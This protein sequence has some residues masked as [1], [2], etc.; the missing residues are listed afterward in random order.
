MGPFTL[1]LEGKELLRF[2]H[3]YAVPPTAA[4]QHTSTLLN[5][6]SHV[7]NIRHADERGYQAEL[8][9]SPLTEIYLTGNYSESE[10]KHETAQSA[11]DMAAAQGADGEAYD[12][13]TTEKL[14]PIRH[15][16]ERVGRNAPCP[17]GSG[18][19]YKNCCMRKSN[20]A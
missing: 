19:K 16:G 15:R 14:E 20:V 3:A 10:A 2:D 4:R 17:C 11:V 6:G 12:G 5:R 9:W 18:K 1:F 7:P 8:M 13:N